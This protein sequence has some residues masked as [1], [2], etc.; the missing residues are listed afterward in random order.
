[1]TRARDRL[2]LSSALKEGELTIGRGALAEVLP[3]S[4]KDMF[5]A[6]AVATEDTIT[7]TSSAGRAFEW[8][9][10]RASDEPGEP[11]ST[12]E[13]DARIVLTTT[14]LPATEL[15]R[16]SVSEWLARDHAGGA[17]VRPQQTQQ[18]LIGSL[19]HRLFQARVSADEDATAAARAALRIEER[20]ALEDAEH[21]IAS[22]AAIWTSLRGRGDVG[23]LLDAAT[24]LTEV[25]FSM[26]HDA[27]DGPAIVRGTIDCLA[28]ADSGEVTVVEFKTGGAHRSHQLQLE[29]YVAAAQSL[30]PG[31]PVSGRLIYNSGE[32]AQD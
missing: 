31:T 2:Y 23:G 30:F 3:Q 26:R 32:R 17:A 28:I 12:T 13:P 20:A 21:V 11:A 4:L 24:V 22:A 15:P 9:V 1:M 10:V 7:W 25:P 18:A 8:R 16:L 6:A 5:S 29:L 19:V 14:T 27:A